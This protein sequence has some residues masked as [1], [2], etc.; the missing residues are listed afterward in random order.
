M[1]NGIRHG[2]A[3]A[4]L[5]CAAAALAGC[6]GLGGTVAGAGAGAAASSGV[7]Y[8]LNGV[9]YKTYTA[10]LGQVRDAVLTSMGR[11]GM[12]L[13]EDAPA[14][15]GHRIVAA[16]ADREIEIGL[17]RLTDA[18]TRM[19]VA[20]GQGLFLNDRATA[21]EIVFQTGIVLDDRAGGGRAKASER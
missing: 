12:T 11:M 10:G 20:A 2:L 13:R 16:A 7:E 5:L 21:A 4:A 15:N 6:G 1:R 9:A 18:A 17:E 19:R 8:T 3:G 14:G